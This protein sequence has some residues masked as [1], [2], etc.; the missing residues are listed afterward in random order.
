MD[1]ELGYEVLDRV[2]L[3]C[4]ESQTSGYVSHEYKKHETLSA[5]HH[6]IATEHGEG[7]WHKS[8]YITKEADCRQSATYEPLSKEED[9]NGII[10]N[11]QQ[12]SFVETDPK[13]RK[14]IRL[15]LSC[16]TNELQQKIAEFNQQRDKANVTYI[17]DNIANTRNNLT[18]N[19]SKIKNMYD[20]YDVTLQKLGAHDALN[21]ALANTDH[22]H[23]IYAPQLASQ[24]IGFC[25]TQMDNTYFNDTLVAFKPEQSIGAMF[26][27]NLLDSREDGIDASHSYHMSIHEQNARTYTYND[28]DHKAVTQHENFIPMRD[29]TSVQRNL[30]AEIPMDSMRFSDIE[31]RDANADLTASYDDGVVYFKRMHICKNAYN[32]QYTMEMSSTT[33]IAHARVYCG[34]GTSSGQPYFKYFDSL[35]Y[36]SL[37]TNAV[38]AYTSVA[39]ERASSI[40]NSKNSTFMSPFQ[41]IEFISP[42]QHQDNDGL[43][44]SNVF[45]VTVKDTGIQKQQHYLEQNGTFDEHSA[46]V[47]SKLDRIKTD[48]VHAVQDIVKN[49]APANTQLFNVYF[50]DGDAND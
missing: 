25:Q 32:A 16:C 19:S 8:D 7:Y 48:I 49:S 33:Q 20:I 34:I 31:A 21:P 29:Y 14:Y 10:L 45:T 6:D 13:S 42:V 27:S 35:N 18:C 17:A 2:H 46:D 28:K 5:L 24:P 40:D 26:Q 12:H 3:L 23:E 4:A 1:T 44:K 36:N 47:Q 9:N 50:E 30:V 43:H 22:H 11:E 39:T 37:P 15:Y 41:K 38:G